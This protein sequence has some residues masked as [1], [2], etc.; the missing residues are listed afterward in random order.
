MD[1]LLQLLATK[2]PSGGAGSAAD[3]D[4]TTAQLAALEAA[5][6][7]V[8]HAASRAQQEAEGGT[9]FCADVLQ[10]LLRRLLVGGATVSGSATSKSSSHQLANVLT[11]FRAAYVD[12]YDDVR[13]HTLRAVAALAEA[14]AEA[15]VAAQ[16]SRSSALGRAAVP[17]LLSI[18][19][20]PEATEA[21]S[22]RWWTDG[23]AHDPAEDDDN[24]ELA[25][26]DDTKPDGRLSYLREQL[27]PL[28]PGIFIGG[29]GGDGAFEDGDDHSG[30]SGHSD[31]SSD[32]ETGVGTKR[33]TAAAGLRSEGDN[34]PRSSGTAAAQANKGQHG[35][36]SGGVGGPVV[37]RHSDPR[38]KYARL[39]LQRKA[40]AA[41]WTAVRG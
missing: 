32:D 28:L 36:S 13:Y 15:E 3:D 25:D 33:S 2:P 38:P 7:F 26:N 29:G 19:L 9:R 14:E 21:A 24:D 12:E 6:S 17:F 31:S 8:A 35:G 40:W 22:L 27:E 10:W 23:G 1:A 18:A 39:G 11:T 20:P 34:A 5:V 16:S 41:A 4:H 37:N 30:D